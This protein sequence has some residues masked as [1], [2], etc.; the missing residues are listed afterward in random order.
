MVKIGGIYKP[1]EVSFEDKSTR[2]VVDAIRCGR[3]EYTNLVT[4]EYGDIPI[5]D[6]GWYYDKTRK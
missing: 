1:S 3:V 6:F 2:I 4:N 5:D